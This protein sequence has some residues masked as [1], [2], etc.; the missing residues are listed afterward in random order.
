MRLAIVTSH[1]IQ[2]NAPLFKLLTE[3]RNIEVMVFY[4]WGKA[5]HEKKYDPGFGRV[6]DWDIPLLQGYPSQFLENVAPMPGSHH[7]KGIDNPGAVQQI[8]Q[9]KP[10]AILLFGWSFKSHLHLMRHYKGKI[11]VYF[12]GDSTLLDDRPG[13]K[14]VLRRI[15]LRW[16]Y[17]NVDTA[18]YVGTNN[19]KYFERNGLR[20]DQLVLAPHAINNDFFGSEKERFEQEAKSWRMDLGIEADDIVF[21]FAGKLEQKKAPLLLH[22]AF[23]NCA[24]PATVHLVFVGNGPQ[25]SELRERTQATNIHF[26]EFQNQTRMPVVY[27]LGDAVILPSMGPGET[28]GLALNEAMACGRPVIA[29]T[30]CGG[31]IDLIRDGVNGFIFEAGNVDQLSDK[32]KIMVISGKKKVTAMGDKSLEHIQHFS[33]KNIAEAIERTVSN[34]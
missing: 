32:M 34:T 25:E 6:V 2:Y 12:R 23:T 30:M 16:V 15:F 18:F 22:E 21:V 20:E 26:V 24:F 1:P 33:M 17:R 28:W 10:D 31:A 7:F 5:A 19:K 4:S 29:S 8:D 9:W 14:S 3:R 11:P 27:R 13:L